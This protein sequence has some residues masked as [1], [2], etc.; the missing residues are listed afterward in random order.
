MRFCKYMLLVWKSRVFDHL[1]F[2][3]LDML[4]N[5]HLTPDHLKQNSHQW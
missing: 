4:I 2:K 1:G 5:K 3:P